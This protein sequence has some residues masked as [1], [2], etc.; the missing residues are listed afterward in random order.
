MDNDHEVSRLKREDREEVKC[1]LCGEVFTIAPWERECGG[2]KYCSMQ[3]YGLSQIIGLDDENNINQI[4]KQDKDEDIICEL[5]GTKFKSHPCRI[6]SNNVKKYCSRPCEDLARLMG[7]EVEEEIRHM[8]SNEKIEHVCEVCGKTY[9]KKPYYSKKSNENGWHKFCSKQCLGTYKSIHESGPNHPRWK[10]GISYEPYCI[11]FNE[12]FKERVRAFWGNKCV[13]C[14]TS[15]GDKYHEKLTVHHVTYDKK[16]CCNGEIPLFVPLCTKHHTQTNA[17]RYEWEIWFKYY[18]WG[19][20][21]GTMNTYYTKEETEAKE[22]N[23]RQ[24]G[25]RPRACVHAA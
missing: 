6:K 16:V 21:N 19:A 11:K 7:F 12:E 5:C 24:A 20:T 1:L 4:R 2:D 3:C 10:G 22:N 25:P 18:I 17:D 15:R 9:K 8:R 14:G 23:F 13:I